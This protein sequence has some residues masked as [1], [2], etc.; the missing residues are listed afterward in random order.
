MQIDFDGLYDRFGKFDLNGRV[1]GMATV[2][3]LSH[4][5]YEREHIDD[6]DLMGIVNPPV[7]YVLG[8][9]NWEGVQ[10]IWD[11]M[12][13]TLYSLHKMIRLLLKSNPNVLGF[14]WMPDYVVSTPALEILIENRDAFSSRFAYNPFVKYAEAQLNDMERSVYKGYLGKKRKELRDKFGYDTKH[15]AHCIRILRMGAEFLESGRMHVDRSNLDAEQ[16][17]EIRNGEYSFDRIKV[18]ASLA[19]NR[20]EVAY[21]QSRL[22]DYPNEVRVERVLMELQAALLPAWLLQS[23]TNHRINAGG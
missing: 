22:P 8:L 21:H 20:A 5:T 10:I 18:M 9:R 16:L 19:F 7:N 15:A 14:L 6:I 23:E 3:S 1:I 13:V 11:D 12:D 2:G 4:G 17:I